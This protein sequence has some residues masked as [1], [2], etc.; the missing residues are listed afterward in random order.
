MRNETLAT[1]TGVHP[2]HPGRFPARRPFAG[3]ACRSTSGGRN[4]NHL[5][6]LAAIV[7][8]CWA[9]VSM[10]V[11][12]DGFSAGTLFG[13]GIFYATATG[14]QFVPRGMNYVRLANDV[15]GLQAPDLHVTLDP[16]FYDP[17]RLAQ[18]VQAMRQSGYN[19]V[20]FTLDCPFA[21][22][23][24]QDMSGPGIAPA[25]AAVVDSAL[26]I[27]ASYDMKAMFTIVNLPLNYVAQAYSDGAA[28]YPQAGWGINEQLFNPEVV[29]ARGRFWADLLSALPAADWATLFSIDI[30]GEIQADE[31]A[32]PFAGASFP[33][34]EFQ[35]G[36]YNL[37]DYDVASPTGRQALLDAASVALAN[38]VVAAI[39]QVDPDM[40]V[41]MSV[42]TPMQLGHA[43]FDGLNAANVTNG[44]VLYPARAAIL[45]SA[46][47][48]DY[49]DLHE[50]PPAPAFSTDADLQAAGLS[51]TAL[52]AKPIVMSEYGVYAFTFPDLAA[53]AQDIAGRMSETCK[54]GFSGWAF[55]D[56]D[57]SEFLIP[58][59]GAQILATYYA[60]EDGGVLNQA[61]SPNTNPNFCAPVPAGPFVASAD[62][63]G[64]QAVFYSNGSHYCVYDTWDHFVS[65]SGLTSET[66]AALVANLLLAANA[67]VPPTM[68]YD[69]V[70]QPPPIAAGV[71]VAAV[72]GSAGLYYSNG[73]H[74]CWYDSWADF[75]ALNGFGTPGAAAAYVAQ[76]IDDPYAAIPSVMVYDGACV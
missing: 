73:S 66:A 22:V 27:T 41:T 46:T 16:A 23:L 53:S 31:T 26:Q 67:R 42:S 6:R 4:V 49:I 15:D 75:L 20:R 63:A 14:Q 51:E 21:Y 69:G 70:C 8:C 37:D 56:W 18:A 48:L 54:Y 61:L 35:G 9:P 24:G 57:T 2:T 60:T 68:P 32:M 52:W 3:V 43:G 50:Y 28:T 72:N 45:D 59:N 76:L 58:A 39:K 10:T 13:Q 62:A 7:W 38:S 19:I 34:F 74:Y 29:A 71:F 44:S 33:L 36:F 65:Y 25:F 47:T 5:L 30:Y 17:A 40:L 1:E 11:R 55:W 64:D 12:A